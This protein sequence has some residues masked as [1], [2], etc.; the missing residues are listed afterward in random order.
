MFIQATAN[1]VAAAIDRQIATYGG[2]HSAWYVGISSDPNDRLLSGHNATSEHNA[3][4]YWDATNEETARVIEDHFLDKG[5]QGGTGGGDASSR[6][7]YVY[8]VTSLTRE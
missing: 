1:D 2:G 3:A 7:V 5:C 6:Y 4:L 8:K